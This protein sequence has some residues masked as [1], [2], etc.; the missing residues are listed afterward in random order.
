MEVMYLPMHYIMLV[1][2]GIL[3]WWDFDAFPTRT[4]KTN[5]LAVADENFDNYRLQ[6]TNSNYSPKT[7]IINKYT[8]QNENQQHI[9]LKT[10]TQSRN[11]NVYLAYLKP[12]MDI[13]DTV[14]SKIVA[15]KV[16]TYFYVCDVLYVAFSLYLASLYVSYY[17]NE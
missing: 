15:N 6:S 17:I 1:S 12:E 11:S 7:S 14:F 9:F 8:Y 10:A 4:G 13:F 2:C 5:R 16:V 3:I